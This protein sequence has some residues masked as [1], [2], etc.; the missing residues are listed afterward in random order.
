MQYIH[1]DN[2]HS[3]W[4]FVKSGIARIHERAPDRW[5]AEDAYSMIKNGSLHLYMYGDEGFAMLQPIRGW[6]GP[7]VYVFA[8]YITPGKDFMTEA[9]EE[10]KEIAKQAGAKRIKF[11]SKR[12]GWEKKAYDLGY[13]FGHVEYEVQL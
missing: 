7:E 6:D 11:Q 10:V 13:E 3:V 4:E 8:A 1:P 5:M 12:R 9:F 2:L